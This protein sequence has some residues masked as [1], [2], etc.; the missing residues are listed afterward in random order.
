MNLR[1]FMHFT[2]TMD[3]H[4]SY[5]ILEPYATQAPA[6]AGS[7]FITYNDLTLSQKWH[8]VELHSILV[9]PSTSPT[10]T[11]DEKE[12]RLFLLGW[13]KEDERPRVMIP[14]AL[15][16]PLSTKWFKTT[17]SSLLSHPAY[18]EAGL[19]QSK[20]CTPSTEGESDPP[21]I[22]TA[23]VGKDSSVVYY[24]VAKGIE[25]PHDVPE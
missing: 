20:E 21:V 8:R 3:F 18:I 4:S 15:N 5:K 12:I 23:S 19:P 6:Q 17:F 25:K 2:A 1:S 24:R 7:L 16:Q 10:A 11:L 14:M 13:R 22:Y 9:E